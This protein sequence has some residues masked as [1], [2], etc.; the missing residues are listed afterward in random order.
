MLTGVRARGLK[1]LV[2]LQIA[3]DQAEFLMNRVAAGEASWDDI[4]EELAA[5]YSSAGFINVADFI[6]A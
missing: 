6:R 2:T 1:I 3:V 5:H 4:R